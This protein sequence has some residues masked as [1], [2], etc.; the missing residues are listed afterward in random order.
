MASVSELPRRGSHFHSLSPEPNQA[1]PSALDFCPPSSAFTQPRE[2]VVSTADAQP[3]F[4]IPLSVQKEGDGYLVGNSEMGDF[5]QFPGQGL[6]ILRMLGSGY[7][8]TAIKARLASEDGENVDVDAFIELL[9][10]IGFVHRESE[11]QTVQERLRAATADKRRIFSADPRVARAIF[12]APA[13]ACGACIALCA[14][15]EMIVDPQLRINFSAFYT[16]TNRTAFLLTLLVLSFL[17][18]AMHESGHM[19]AAARHGVKS[20]YTIGNRLWTIVAESD[21]TGILSLPKSKRYFPMLAGVLVDILCA[22]LL[23]FLL[24]V[25]L[26]HGS[27][28][29]TIQIVQALVLSMIIGVIWQF[30]IFVKTDVYFVLCNYFGHPDLDR[31]AMV[32]LRDLMHRTTFGLFG[33]KSATPEFQNRFMLQMFTAIWLVGRV[34]SLAILFCVFLPTMAR[35]LWS[36]FQMLKGPPESIWMACDT[37]MYVVI[38]LTML[39]TGMYMW[40]KNR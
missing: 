29:F 26:Q 33:S 37:I 27:S 4:V 31:E 25:L 24:K 10:S 12:S 40:L 7:D 23:T 36:A 28:A 19:L 38:T 8:A 21:L 18:V 13:L 20:R 30:N 39:S 35:Y 9:S 34:M 5:Y 14:A 17:Q 11:R 32:Y 2:I 6:K 1:R 22:A 16:E 3:Y 15:F